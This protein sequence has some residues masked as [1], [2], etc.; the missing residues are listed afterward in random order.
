[1]VRR[2]DAVAGGSSSDD[3]VGTENKRKKLNEDDMS[4]SDDS[5]N[6]LTKTIQKGE[7]EEIIGVRLET[8][9]KSTVSDDREKLYQKSDKGP[10]FVMIEKKEINEY[11]FA[12][13][14]C[15]LNIK[16]IGEIVKMS[17]NTLRVKCGSF[18][19]ANKLLG[20]SVV[21][22]KGYKCFIPSL[23]AA[24]VGIARGIPKTWSMEE[25][26][27]NIMSA[28]RVIEVERM[29]YWDAV[30]G[31]SLESESVKITFR[32]YK[33]P[34]EIKIYN[35]LT[36]LTMFIPKP[37]FCRNCLRYGHTIKYCKS[38][39][40]CRICTASDHDNNCSSEPKCNICKEEPK[41][42]TNDQNCN[43]RKIQVEIKKEM[44]TEKIPFHEAN[45]VVRGRVND[46]KNKDKSFKDAQYVGILKSQ[47]EENEKLLKMV[48][49][50]ILN[51]K[52]DDVNTNSATL[53]RINTHMYR[54]ICQ[55][56]IGKETETENGSQ[57]NANKYQKPQA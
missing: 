49:N 38:E 12:K 31:K 46:I 55:N 39:K 23:F 13:F 6:L 32:S 22:Q 28:S 19:S 2:K 51:R 21:E 15:T 35:V 20:N 26:K 4:D 27:E 25:I 56:N 30:A 33:L 3:A 53:L 34:A 8:T 54:Y 40:L 57:N 11:L 50:E 24:S 47:V 5:T 7:I 9:N 17:R 14:V 52:A 16:E 36:K 48:M 1:M 29:T 42:Q 10:F 37:L 18:S 45:K 44:V 43:E 41:H